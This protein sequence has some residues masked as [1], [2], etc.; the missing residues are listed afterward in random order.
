MKITYKDDDGNLVYPNTYIVTKE[1]ALQY[2]VKRVN[3]N[4]NVRV[5]P[6]S[7]LKIKPDIDEEVS[8]EIQWLKAKEENNGI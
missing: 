2:P 7:K 6:I 5:I 3:S 1:E 8:A 4:V